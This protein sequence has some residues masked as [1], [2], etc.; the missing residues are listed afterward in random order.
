MYMYILELPKSLGKLSTHRYLVYASFIFCFFGI[1][2]SRLYKSKMLQIFL[3]SGVG[4]LTSDMP[5]RLGGC[6]S[7]KL[8]S[9]KD[10][11]L[12]LWETF[13]SFK[14]VQRSEVRDSAAGAGGGGRGGPGI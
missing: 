13:F 6:P 1:S 2:A 7:L 12:L 14:T 10:Q 9:E 3:C 8:D 4:C 5:L 11:E